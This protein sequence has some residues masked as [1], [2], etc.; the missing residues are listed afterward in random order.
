MT[1][2]LARFSKYLFQNFKSTEL[3]ELPFMQLWQPLFLSMHFLSL[4]PL[5]SAGV[6]AAF[7][8]LDVD[9]NMYVPKEECPFCTLYCWELGHSNASTALRALV[10]KVCQTSFKNGLRNHGLISLRRI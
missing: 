9:G 6:E 3:T 1:K 7:H 8:A 10:A 4:H 2:A 5:L